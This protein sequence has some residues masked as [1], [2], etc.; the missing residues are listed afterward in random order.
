MIDHST[1]ISQRSDWVLLSASH[2]ILSF[3]ALTSVLIGIQFLLGISLV[4]NEYT[5]LFSLGTSCVLTGIILNKVYGQKVIT[6]ILFIS[7]FVFITGVLAWTTGKIY[8][9]SWDG[10]A[11]HQISIRS[12]ANGWNPVYELIPDN[13]QSS[14]HYEREI[15]LSIWVN[16]YSKGQ[17]QFAAAMMALTGNIESG[18]VFNLLLIVAAFCS[19]LYLMMR[20]NFFTWLWNLVIAMVAALNPITVNQMFSYYL[21]GAVASCILILITQ[22]ILV[23]IETDSKRQLGAFWLIGYVSIVLINLKFT[24]LVYHA[25]L[26]VVF[27]GLLLYAKKY[28]LSRKFITTMSISALFA[29]LVAGYNPYITNTIEKGHPFYPIEGGSKVDVIVHMVPPPLKHHNTASRF[30]LSTFSRCDNVSEGSAA[31]L[32]YKIPFTF[33]VQ[34]LKVL[35]SEGIRLG[36]FGVLWSGIFLLSII[37]AIV[38]ITSKKNKH[39]KYLIVIL[40]A[41]VGSV[42]INPVSWWARFVPQ[43]WLFPIVVL[44]ILMIQQ[45]AAVIHHAVKSVLLL[46]MANTLIIAAVYLYSVYVNTANANT[47]FEKLKMRT[48]PVY[49]YTDIFSPNVMKL[50]YHKI[51]YV[52]V[53]SYKELPCSVP[54]V[55]LKMDLC[56]D[57]DPIICKASQ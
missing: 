41:I 48:T 4:K 9:K 5:I 50:K 35:Q 29:I 31:Q 16:H 45:N 21:D 14:K 32:H 25:W 27:L 20:L 38:A 42:A 23:Y 34:E 17:E 22:L 37:G 26:G 30:F 54:V 51:P 47:F 8:D 46:M 36:G 49:V 53:K 24:G 3:L 15:N 2:F 55:V 33:T 39:R 52:E 40:F 44:V 57:N 11:Y 7:L 6:S 19:A 43:L 10:M 28:Q 1:K 13:P 56:I 12:M 18:K